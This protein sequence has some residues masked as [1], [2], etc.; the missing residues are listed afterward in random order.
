M[1]DLKPWHLDSFDLLK[2]AEQHRLDDGDFDKRMALISFDNSIES[3]IITY[4]SLNPIQRKGRSFQKSDVE[5]WLLNFHTKIEFFEH[6]IVKILGLK[7]E[8]GREEIIY[9]HVLRNDLYHAGKGFVPRITDIDGIRK[10]ALWIFSTL[11]EIDCESLLLSGYEED[12][13]DKD[14]YQN[15]MSAEN[16]LLEAFISF[17]KEMIGYLGE[18]K[19]KSIQNEPNIVEILQEVLVNDQDILSKQNLNLLE[20]VKSSIDIIIQGNLTI[21]EKDNELRNITNQ[22]QNLKKQVYSKLREYQAMIVDKA[23][24]ATATAI[25]LENKHIGIVSQAQGSGLG[26]SMVSF[27]ISFKAMQKYNNFQIIIVCDSMG[28]CEQAYTQFKDFMVSDDNLSSDYKLATILSGK[29]RLS[30][31][32]SEKQPKVIF[33]TLSHLRANNSNS[34]FEK[35]C[36]IVVYNIQSVRILDEL[37]PSGFFILFT[38]YASQESSQFFGEY[39]VVYSLQEAQK[40]RNVVPFEFIV[41]SSLNFQDSVI[42]TSQEGLRLL[43]EEI[44]TDFNMRQTQNIGKGIIIVPNIDFGKR[45][46]NEML[47]IEKESDN[48]SK[49]NKR[50]AMVSSS[51]QP[52]E[53]SK[54]LQQFSDNQ[55][56][57]ELLITAGAFID[58]LD[59]PIIHI[60]YLLK[61]IN[62]HLVI[63]QLIGLVNKLYQKKELGIIIDYAQNSRIFKESII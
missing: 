59:N 5:K 41:K 38:S 56:S 28:A 4:L 60:V 51:M 43:A 10:V 48:I 53:K 29:Y 1:S 35:P 40:E 19:N 3:S 14:I 36:L 8:I 32:I 20:K 21:G 39:I 62:N 2:H 16:T 42:N 26:I 15:A 57:L 30:D 13:K 49:Q 44:L 50:I 52:L 63:Q 46:L 7:M 23:I 12:L 37:F 25:D 54:L 31:Y 18:I 27:I 33:T 9:Y 58:G 55:N 24:V 17:K 22:F 34:Y 47:L 61:N 11:F 45:L 6:Y